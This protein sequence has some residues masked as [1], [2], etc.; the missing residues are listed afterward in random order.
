VK[1]RIT[2]NLDIDTDT[3]E[4]HC[5]ECQQA[6]GP[7]TRNFKEGCLIDARDPHEVWQPVIDGGYTF[8]YDP[9]WTRLVEY[10]CPNCGFLIDLD[11]LPPGH[12]I[13]HDIQP[14]LTT[15]VAKSRAGNGG[16]PT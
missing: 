15:L 4:W 5:H 16:E 11:V 7:A 14:D 6:L 13:P 9:E 12:P 3:L 2:E 10:Y 1:R 8:S